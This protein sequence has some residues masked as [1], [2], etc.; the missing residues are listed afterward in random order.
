MAADEAMAGLLLGE[1]ERVRMAAVA[2]SCKF[3]F[4]DRRQEMRGPR[5]PASTILVLLLQNLQGKRDS[6]QV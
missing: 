1:A 4:G 3:E 6:V 5:A 2:C